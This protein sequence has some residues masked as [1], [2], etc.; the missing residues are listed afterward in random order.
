MVSTYCLDMDLVKLEF[1]VAKH[2]LAKKDI[3][4]INDVVI[5]HA[6]LK[7]TFPVLVRVLQIAMTIFVTS[8]QCE[9]F[10]STLKHIKTYLHSLMSEQHLTDLAVLSIERD[11]SDSLDL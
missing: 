5:E 11:I 4:K 9:R 8:V 6:S 1:P 7:A 2:T 10:F 3:L